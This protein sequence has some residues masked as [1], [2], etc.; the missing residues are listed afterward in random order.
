MPQRSDH[1]LALDSL[2]RTVERL[3]KNALH[4]EILDEEGDSIQ[5]E[6]DQYMYSLLL[7][8]S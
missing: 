6:Y 1:K 5:D 4:C 2:S 7:F 3:K 8:L